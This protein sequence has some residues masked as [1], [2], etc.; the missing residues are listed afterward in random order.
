MGDIQLD[1]TTTNPMYKLRHEVR[2]P[3]CD[4]TSMLLLVVYTV[5][6]FTKKVGTV[7]YAVLNIF[8]DAASRDKAQ[9]ATQNVKDFVVN[10]G[11]F[12]IRLHKAPPPRSAPLSADALNETPAVPCATLLV[13]LRPAAKSKDGLRTLSTADVDERDWVATGLV[14]PMPDYRDGMYDSTRAVPREQAAKLYNRRQAHRKDAT[15]V[16]LVGH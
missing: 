10:T 9:P 12:E 3:S 11:G 8:V 2:E 15:R 16:C 4:P 5:D 13:R 7:G 1:S 14:Q 6:K